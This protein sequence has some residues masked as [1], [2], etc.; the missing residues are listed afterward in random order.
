MTH[1]SLPPSRTA[2]PSFPTSIIAAAARMTPQPVRKRDPYAVERF[3][4]VNGGVLL[5]GYDGRG[6]VMIELRVSAA[7][8]SER[9]VD[10]MRR[11]VQANDDAPP[12]IGLVR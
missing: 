1:R 9:M 2:P 7:R 8:Y 12:P 10:K 4:S 3:P 11:W 6:E 5:V